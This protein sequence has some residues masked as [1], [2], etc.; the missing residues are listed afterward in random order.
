MII[1]T[2][3]LA[4]REKAGIIAKE[5]VADDGFRPIV[6]IVGDPK[7][8]AAAMADLGKVELGKIGDHKMKIKV[9]SQSS[10]PE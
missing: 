8:A 10:N 1:S 9:C 2:S 3:E 6:T 7:G 5:I 4:F